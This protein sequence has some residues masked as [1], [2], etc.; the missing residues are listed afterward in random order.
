MS[1]GDVLSP[2]TFLMKICIV[3]TV[4]GEEAWEVE[5]ETEVMLLEREAMAV[6]V[7]LQLFGVAIGGARG[8]PSEGGKGGLL[9]MDA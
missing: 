5:E 3:S 1:E 6:V 9:I 8:W 4:S 2:E 7:L